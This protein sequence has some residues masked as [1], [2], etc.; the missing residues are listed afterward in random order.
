[1]GAAKRVAT[2]QE[3]FGGRALG[4]FFDQTAAH[5]IQSGERGERWVVVVVRS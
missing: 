5:N 1:M 3:L 4:L 2:Y